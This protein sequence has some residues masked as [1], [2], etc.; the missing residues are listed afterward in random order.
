MHR[1]WTALRK[2]IEGAHAAARWTRGV[3]LNAARAATL[4]LEVIRCVVQTSWPLVEVT[5]VELAV[6]MTRQQCTTSW[7][8]RGRMPPWPTP[9]LGATL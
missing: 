9:W 8:F 1:G 6:T 2:E 4:L 5:V 7:R 3:G